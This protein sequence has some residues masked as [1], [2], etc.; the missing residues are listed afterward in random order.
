MSFPRFYVINFKYIIL[1]LAISLL[2]VFSFIN[3]ATTELDQVALEDEALYRA[4]RSDF[5]PRQITHIIFSYINP[6]FSGEIKNSFFDDIGVYFHWDDWMDL[7]AGSTI[8]DKYREKY[9]DGQC[10]AQLKK[11]ADVSAY[12]IESYD[13]KVLRGTTD[14]YCLKD[15]PER[16]I[17]S[18][19]KSMVEVPV[20]GK[21]R[22]GRLQL[23]KT[24]KKLLIDLMEEV[25]LNFPSSRFK[26]IDFQHLRPT[27]NVTMDE[28]I[29]EPDKEI[30]HLSDKLKKGNINKTEHERLNFLEYSTELAHKSNT[31][32]KYPWIATDLIKGKSHHFAYPFFTRYM[33][34]RER[35]SVI[36]HMVRAWF[37]FAENNNFTSWV[38]YGSLLGWAFNGLNLPWD[39]DVDVQMPIKQLERLGKE[40]NRTLIIENPRYG[41][42]KYFLEVSSTYVTQGNG[43]NFIDARFI[44]INSA[45]YIDISGLTH[46]SHKVPQKDYDNLRSLSRDDDPFCFHCKNWNWHSLDEIFPIRHT[47]FEGG[48]VYIPNNVSHILK[49]KYGE[50]SYTKKYHYLDYNYQEDLGL[51]IP[52]KICRS[53]PPGERFE[54]SYKNDLTLYGACG[55][56]YLQDEYRIARPCIERHLLFNKD[57]DSSAPYDATA[58]GDLPILRKDLSE[59]YLD[60]IEKGVKDNS[61]YT[62]QDVIY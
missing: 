24:S 14:L 1:L 41:N 30:L 57:I 36:Q 45:L 29:L 43:K 26:S 56:P 35:Q 37:Q 11:F 44:D 16:I 40:F 33:S 12:T 31:Y 17:V 21:K 23:P 25:D 32:F 22:M 34:N 15:I 38:N 28:F 42:S 18:T 4:H 61:W 39:T 46:T 10:D 58:L 9:P 55:D 50:D 52:D 48:S 8:L 51:W 49:K 6:R 5:D 60:I 2:A 53:P 19:D 13:K 3:F 54:D 7:N 27:R 20:V 47:Y 59:Y 62:K